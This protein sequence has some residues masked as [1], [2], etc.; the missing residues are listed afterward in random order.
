MMETSNL[1]LTS[2]LLMDELVGWQIKNGKGRDENDLRFGQYIWCK[3]EMKDM[4]DSSTPYYKSK[5]L[6]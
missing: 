4:F 3:Y 2:E 5:N 6:N 1:T